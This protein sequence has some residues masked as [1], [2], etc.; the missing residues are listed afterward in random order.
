MRLLFGIVVGAAL[1]VGAAYIYDMRVTSAETTGS[2]TTMAHRPM[3]NWDVVGQNWT[4][5]QRRARDA[6]TAL[7]HKITS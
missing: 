6:W 7:S 4:T 5:V 2:A 1:T 3:V